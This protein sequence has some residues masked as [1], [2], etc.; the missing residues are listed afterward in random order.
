[1]QA[2][3]AAIRERLIKIAAQLQAHIPS[4]E[5]FSI[6]HGNWSFPGLTRSDLTEDVQA[7]I[8]EIDESEDLPLGEKEVLLVDYDRRLAYILSNTI[9]NI[10]GNAAVGVPALML[11]LTGLRKALAPVMTQRGHAE[12]VARLKRITA[13]VRSMEAR[14]TAL[15]PRTEILSSMVDRIERAHNAADQLPT[16]L[17]SLAEARQKISEIAE[18]SAKD[19]QKISD[20]RDNAESSEDKLKAALDYADDVL[21]R[22][23]TAYAGSTSVGLAAAFSERSSSLSKSMWIWVG[24]LILSLAAGSYFGSGHLRNLSELFILPNSSP[25]IIALNLVLSI[26]SVA[27]PIWFAWIST[28]Q[29]GQRFRLAEDYA[30]KASVSRAYEGFRRE[31]ARFDT[32][33]EAK[34]LTSA[35]SRFDELPLRLIE[36]ASHGSPWHELAS[37]DTIK[38]ALKVVP[39]FTD[40]VRSLAAKSIDAMKPMKRSRTAPTEGE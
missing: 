36:T 34:L 33:M 1:M 9:P 19:Q 22:C 14:I 4:D 24:G 20:I 35:L 30:F 32:A 10:W 16:D 23:E 6:A 27:A 29:I 37:S 40:Q 5:P 25:Y 38:Q 13:Q 11:T 3:V 2:A 39:D 7:I 21:K 26:F 12:Y 28:K 31:T 15:D 17:E 8:D 18:N